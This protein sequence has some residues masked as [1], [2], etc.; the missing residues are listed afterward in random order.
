VLQPL[1]RDCLAGPGHGR[2][3]DVDGQNGG[4]QPRRELARP[5]AAPTADIN[6]PTPRRE[7]AL[8]DHL[9]QQVPTTRME[10]LLKIMFE[11]LTF[12]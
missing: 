6:D 4:A 8:L 5:V 9:Q 3:D 11:L 1:R 12:A 10:T 2:R 7:T